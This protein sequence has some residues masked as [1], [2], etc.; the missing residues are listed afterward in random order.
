MVRKSRKAAK[1]GTPA[2]YSCPHCGQDLAN[3]TPED[4]RRVKVHRVL[5]IPD[6]DLRWKRMDELLAEQRDDNPQAAF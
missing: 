1:L 3:E 4:Q 5:H 2:S 6:S